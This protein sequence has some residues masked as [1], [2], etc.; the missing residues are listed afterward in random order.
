MVGYL[1]A[2]QFLRPEAQPDWI[3]EAQLIGPV[4]R[5]SALLPWRLVP[6]RPDDPAER[7]LAAELTTLV[8]RVPR[9]SESS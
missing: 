6:E 4:Q 2:S 1:I 8:R 5:G 9:S 3:T 7:E